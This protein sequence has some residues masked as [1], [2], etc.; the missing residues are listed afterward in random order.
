MFDLSWGEL[1]LVGVIALVV[2]G[3]RE[4][5][6]VLRTVGQ[7]IAKVR[8]MAGDFQA[9]FNAAMREAEIEEIRNSVNDI[10][11]TASRAATYHTETVFK[12]LETVRNELRDVIKQSDSENKVEPESYSIDPAIDMSLGKR[13]DT[14]LAATYPVP[15]FSLPT[16]AQTDMS[17]LA[18]GKTVQDKR[19]RKNR[20]VIVAAP[21]EAVKPLSRPP[22]RAPRLYKKIKFSA[23]P[24]RKRRIKPVLNAHNEQDKA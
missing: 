9:Q 12:P 17:V 13:A 21:R 10:Q 4:L 6:R 18:T 14:S 24:V 22:K 3:P 8:R 23:F 2:I 1:L 20:R 19:L 16:L 15:D 5:P 11:K 7:T